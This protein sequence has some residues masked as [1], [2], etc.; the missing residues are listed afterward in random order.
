MKRG[1]KDKETEMLSRTIKPVKSRKGTVAPYDGETD[2]SLRDLEDD[3]IGTKE[4]PLDDRL[5]IADLGKKPDKGTFI[6]T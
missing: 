2:M 3:S 4:S 1:K 6:E 5:T